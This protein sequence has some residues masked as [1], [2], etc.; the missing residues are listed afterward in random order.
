MVRLIQALCIILVSLGSASAT[1]I[2]VPGD[3]ATIQE[4]I[5]AAVDGDSV[6]VEPGTYKENLIF[7][8]KQIA[9]RS[10]QGAE[11]TAINGMKVASVVSFNHCGTENTLLEGF[12]LRNGKGNEISNKTYGGGIYLGE[13]C[14]PVLRSLIIDANQAK[15]GGAVY[16]KEACPTFEHCIISNNLGFTYGAGF[17]CTHASDMKL[18]HCT[19][20]ENETENQG[21]G[22]WCSDSEPLILNCIISQNKARRGAGI[23]SSYGEHQPVVVNTNIVMN[24]ASNSASGFYCDSGAIITNSILWNF[25]SSG[26]DE[27]FYGNHGDLQITY[28]VIKGGWPGAG[29]IEAQP[30]FL[31]PY[32]NDFHILSTSP[33]ID[34]GSDELVYLLEYDIDG[35]PRIINGRIDIGVDEFSTP[36]GSPGEYYVPDDYPGIQDAIDASYPG[37]VIIVRPGTYVGNLN[38]KGQPI[39]LK[40]SDGPG[41]TVIDGEGEFIENRPVVVFSYLEKSDSVLQGFTLTN[42]SGCLES[43][44]NQARGGGIYCYKAAP[45]LVDN[46]I[47]HNKAY[48]G[49]G[50]YSSEGLDLITG[51]VLR[52]NHATRGGGICL[53]GGGTIENCTITGNLSGG[54]IYIGTSSPVTI[55]NNLIENNQGGAGIT[56]YWH[57]KITIENNSILNNVNSGDGGGICITGDRINT[58]RNNKIIGNYAL[59]GGGIHSTCKQ[60]HITENIIACNRVEGQGGGIK[61]RSLGLITD[62]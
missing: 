41:Q 42:G 16:G 61:C 56:C 58:I 29:N 8:D 43:G 17:Y 48:H 13:R 57:A 38:F 32:N 5:D 28:S 10:S 20:T 19:I 36:H 3:Y 6:I 25:T 60:L 40:S 35:D 1:D 14:Q 55:R 23:Y 27:I 49:G 50:I 22:I 24:H 18:I 30:E 62:L 4:A 47:E 15:Y 53:Y 52:E 12:T 44:N 59:N 26:M 2:H 31:F 46:I 9:V 39:T 21:G 34:A 51:C 7:L 37:D 45:L 54:G 33:C 11:K